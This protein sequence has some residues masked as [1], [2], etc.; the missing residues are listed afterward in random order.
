MAEFNHKLLLKLREDKG[1][2]RRELMLKLHDIGISISESSI[3]NWETDVSTPDIEKI[4][5]LAKLF[6]TTAEALIK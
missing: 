4:V 6:G 1:W 5:P 3:E 2:S